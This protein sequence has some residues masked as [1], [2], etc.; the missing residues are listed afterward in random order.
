MEGRR[1]RS[2]EEVEASMKRARALKAKET[3]KNHKQSIRYAQT[4]L[5]IIGI[6]QIALGFMSGQKIMRFN[7]TAGLISIAIDAGIGAAYIG[8]FFLSKKKPKQAFIIALCV[9]GA[10]ILIGIAAFGPGS[11]F[12]GILWKIIVVSTFVVGYTAVNKIPPELMEREKDADLLD[13]DF[14]D[15]IIELD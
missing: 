2:K 11:V 14:K 6:L 10:T 13:D 3:L 5:L 7:E 15:E 12:K 4:A 1:Y 9:Y 8:L